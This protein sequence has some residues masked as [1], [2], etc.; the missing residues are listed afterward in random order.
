MSS[1]KEQRRKKRQAK[2]LLWRKYRTDRLL[3]LWEQFLGISVPDKDTT[4]Y[5]DKDPT[6]SNHRRV[7][8]QRIQSNRIKIDVGV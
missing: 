5:P 6:V 8:G 7:V 2:L 4:Y 1:S 3:F